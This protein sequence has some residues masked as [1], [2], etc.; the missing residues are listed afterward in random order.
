MCALAPTVGATKNRVQAL[1]VAAYSLTASWL[2]CVIGLI[3]SLSML[4]ILGLYSLY[5]L[6]I[7]LP[8]LMKVPADKV[9]GYVVASIVC[10]AVVMM[11]AQAIANRFAPSPSVQA[12]GA[13]ITITR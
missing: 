10:A 13:T 1:K 12:G 6:W 8:K 5:L 3:P 9:I 7:G 2:V 11:I 4:W